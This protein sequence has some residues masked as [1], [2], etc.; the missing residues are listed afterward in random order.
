MQAF[1]PNIWTLLEFFAALPMTVANVER[2][3]PVLKRI[4]TYLHNS[5][6]DDRLSSLAILSIHQSII[7]DDEDS[8]RTVD[9]VARQKRR[10]KFNQCLFSFVVCD[11]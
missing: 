4:K 6:G 1:Y 5:M 9:N 7:N 2:S 8:I 10:I 3:L 11:Y